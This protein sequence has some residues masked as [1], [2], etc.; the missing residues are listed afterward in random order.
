[1][2]VFYD[3]VAPEI[4][5]PRDLIRLMNAMSVTW[6]AVGNE[7]DR[8]D[9]IALETLRL[10]RGDVYRAIRANKDR[11]RGLAPRG[12][13]DGRGQA[14]ETDTLLLGSVADVDRPRLRRALMRL[15]PR[16]ESVWSNLHYS[17]DSEIGWVR[18]RRVCTKKNFDSYFRFSVGDEV[19][20]REELNN[21]IAK[22]A[23]TAFVRET[24]RTA[25]LVVRKDRTTKAKLLLDELNIHAEDVAD[26]DV[27]PLLTTLFELGDELDV[28]LDEGRGFSSGDNS[29]R[30]RWLARRLT[31]ERFDLATRSAIFVTACAKAA[32]Y[33]LADFVGFANREHY[34]P[35]ERPR[36]P[37]SE[38]LV[39][40][41]DA[42][43]LDTLA[44]T[45]IRA[46][47]QSGELLK[48]PKLRL[49]LF[50]WYDLAKDNGA[51]VKLWTAE[52]FKSDAAIA[53]FAR[54][55]TTY[56]WSQGLGMA[57]LADTVAKRNTRAGVEHLDRFLD[58]D[59]FRSRVE[60]IDARNVRDADG[61]AIR[62]FLEAWRRQ[63]KNPHD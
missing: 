55:F 63:D 16:L 59:A 8:A 61:T 23:D 48:A 11:I 20:P 30:L 60:E 5:T 49:L 10:L 13:G 39:T 41:T 17:E 51:E 58:L 45:R 53:L 36:A 44:L 15:F 46:A 37:E 62:E 56:S 2:N 50:N 21:L 3:V 18:E 9:F 27:E 25:L 42:L 54:A 34:P 35:N 57:G 40:E 22:A 29:D 24:V 6:P 38:C 31:L 26:A 47:S 33:C 14:G 32:L 4:R 19:L 28:Q 43:A 1:M 52:Q 12:M 7:V